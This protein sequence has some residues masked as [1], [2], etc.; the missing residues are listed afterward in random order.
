M[1]T[2]SDMRVL[3][4]AIRAGR[5]ALNWSQQELADKA[6]VSLPTVTRMEAS[7]GSPKFDTVSR[8]IGALEK[9]GVQFTWTGGGG[10]GVTV[11][12]RKR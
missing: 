12:P 11:V 5:G 7:S 4:A 3:A 1:I 8:L 2:E 9:A 6:G 10:F